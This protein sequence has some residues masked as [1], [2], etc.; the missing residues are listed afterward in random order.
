M[1]FQ[2]IF[3]LDVHRQASIRDRFLIGLETGSLRRDPRG[4]MEQS[5]WEELTTLL[6]G[7]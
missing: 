2:W 5:Q 4:D 7:F 1:R 6:Q 3:A